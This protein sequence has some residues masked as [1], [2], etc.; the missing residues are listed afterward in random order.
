MTRPECWC[1]EPG[2]R[3]HEMDPWGRMEWLCE[4]CSWRRENAEP[5]DPSDYDSHFLAI[6]AHRMEEA[7]RLK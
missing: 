3:E 6:E 7:R 5:R 4:E 2:V 1:G